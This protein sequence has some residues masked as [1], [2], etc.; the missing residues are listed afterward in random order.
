[1]QARLQL[2]H[3][4]SSFISYLSTCVQ[5]DKRCLAVLKITCKDLPQSDM[6]S[7]FFNLTGWVGNEHMALTTTDKG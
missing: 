5:G 4:L 2:R 6:L 1:M 7:S 3:G